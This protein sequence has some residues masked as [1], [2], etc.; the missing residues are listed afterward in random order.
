MAR[1]SQVSFDGEFEF[2]DDDARY[3]ADVAETARSASP[4]AAGSPVT[5]SSSRPT[6]RA[7]IERHYRDGNTER[8]FE[9]EGRQWLAR[10]LPAFIRQSG[11]G[12]P[13]GSRGSSSRVVRRRC[14]ARSRSSTARMGK[15]AYF[16]ELMKASTLDAATRLAVADPGW[17]RDRFGLRAG[18]VPHRAPR[19]ARVGRRLPPR[20]SR[21]CP[22][23]RVRFRVAPRPFGRGGK[24]PL[25][26]GAP[27]RSCSR[28]APRSTRTSRRPACW[29]RS[30]KAATL[31]AAARGLLP[32]ARHG[33]ERLRAPRVLTALAERA[34]HGRLAPPDA[35]IVGDDRLGL[36]A[37]LLPG[38]GRRPPLD[39]DECASHSSRAVSMSARKFERGRVLQA[40]L[41]QPD[42][43]QEVLVRC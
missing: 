35:G 7:T 20:L 28:P 38:A 9:P 33:R 37:G 6:L 19:S 25:H 2:T 29:C 23:H 13:P 43:P 39:R 5:P 17:T 10:V 26:A 22:P 31:D 21:S 36:R 24:G 40:V 8:P 11:I 41:E 32:G 34:I 4:T 15:R 1:S 18:H 14:S 30:P 16:N 12:A 42:V 27:D 3:Q